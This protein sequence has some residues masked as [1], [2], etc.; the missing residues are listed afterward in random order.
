MPLRFPESR[1]KDLRK[2]PFMASVQ[3]TTFTP[4]FCSFFCVK[5]VKPHEVVQKCLG[6]PLS[7]HGDWL[8]HR[9]RKSEANHN[10]CFRRPA[11][12]KSL[13]VAPFPSRT[14]SDSTVSFA[15]D[16]TSSSKVST[17]SPHVLIVVIFNY[18]RLD[19]DF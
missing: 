13:V 4:V 11:Q 8:L 17:P 6:S 19:Y 14:R 7:S 16:A 5:T 3:R 10:Q 12:T 9:L 15:M 18:C 2:W 1:T